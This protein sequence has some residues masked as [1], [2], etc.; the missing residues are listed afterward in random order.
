VIVADH[1]EQL[2]EDSKQGHGQN[3]DEA[4]IRVPLIIRRPGE[5]GVVIEDRF[6][7]NRLRDVIVDPSKAVPTSSLIR[8]H[9][10]PPADPS[11][12][13]R[14]IESTEWKLVEIVRDGSRP[15][16]QEQLFHLPDE[17]KNR[18]GEFPMIAT[19]LRAKLALLP[20][21]AAPHPYDAESAAKLRSLG[22]LH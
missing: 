8:A 10:V 13:W 21:R 22:Y 14:S 18:A 3:L 2:G 16:R 5:S 12:V 17:K 6:S 19:E 1:G 20:F 4:V 9:L 11:V 7:L 15:Y